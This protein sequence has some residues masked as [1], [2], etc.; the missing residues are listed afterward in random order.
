MARSF[1]GTSD[2]ITLAMTSQVEACR[3]GTL[4]A[5]VRRGNN[6]NWNGPLTRRDGSTPLNY[7][8]V[9]PTSHATNNAIWAH[10]A[11]NVNGTP[12][13]LTADGWCIIAATKPTGSQ[14]VRIHKYVF[15]TSTWTHTD[16][17]ATA[18]TG[19]AVGGSVVIGNVAGDFW[20]GDIDV[21]A[22][23]AAAL[24]DAN[25]ESLVSSLSAW[26]TLGPAGM[27]VLDQAS[28]AT[29]VTDRTGNGSDQTALSGT[30]VTP[31]SPLTA[32]AQ[33]RSPQ[34]T[35]QYTSFF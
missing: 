26:D 33:A 12:K 17:T 34:L 14:T 20:L 4:V 10:Y 24:S 1:N 29:A 11:G 7:L 30:T 32:V 15:A 25:I 35:S 5:V 18:D 21:C 3:F 22:I 9:A 2:Q 16:T 31:G 6:T 23:F 27:W 28:T 19:G 13:L 8:D